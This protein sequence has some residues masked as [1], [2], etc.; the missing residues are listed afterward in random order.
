MDA[1]LPNTAS[2]APPSRS[3]SPSVFPGSVGPESARSSGPRSAGSMH[4]RSAGS[5]PHSAG[6]AEAGRNVCVFDLGGRL[7]GLDIACISQAITLPGLR[8]VPA[9]D[10]AV[11]GVCNL[12]GTALTVV[13][14]EAILGFERVSPEPTVAGLTV[15]VL[16][17][18]GLV[19]GAKIRRAEAV[20]PFDA[21]GFRRASDRG[22]HP[23]VAGLLRVGGAKGQVV[24]LLDAD[25]LGE[26][27]EALGYR[28]AGGPEPDRPD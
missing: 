4:P 22:D 8:R 24:T 26:K 21:A 27:L 16:Q 28:R 23:A 15:L 3:D 17:T 18:R 7:Y 11:L 10:A 6:R 1:M 12:R 19:V 2:D 5:R 9:T 20:H 14:L 13:D 25:Y